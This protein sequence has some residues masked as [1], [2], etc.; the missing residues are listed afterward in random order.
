MRW[1]TAIEAPPHHRDPHA[2]TLVLSAQQCDWH[3]ERERFY[4]AALNRPAPPAHVARLNASSLAVAASFQR[5]E[6]HVAWTEFHD[7]ADGLALLEA[8]AAM[9]HRCGLP[10][11]RVWE[12][13][14][15]PTPTGAT[16]VERNDELPMLRPLDGG[17]ARWAN[18]SQGL[19]A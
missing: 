13:Q 1:T 6:L 11:V 8:C 18:V 16:R 2:V 15:M 17:T 19:W 9:A 14:P 5:N 7:D 4:A 3:V 12:T 10:A